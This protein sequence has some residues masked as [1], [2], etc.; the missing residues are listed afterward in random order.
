[1][2]VLVLGRTGMLGSMVYEV[3]SRA[4]GFE[5]FG[6]ARGAGNDHR[7]LALD[8]EQ[9]LQPQFHRL[10]QNGPWD[11]WINCIGVIKPHCKDADP[12]GVRRAI[13][14]NAIFPHELA[15]ASGSANVRLIQIATDCVYSGTKGGYIESDGHDALDVYGKTKSLGEVFNGDALNIRVSIIGPEAGTRWSLLEWFLAQA[16]GAEL[17]GFTHHKWNGIT[18][19]RFAKICENI[20]RQGAYDELL[21]TS[22]VHHYVPQDE[23]TKYEL[24]ELFQRAFGTQFKIQP[25]DAIGPRVDRTL[26]T[27]FNVLHRI[28]PPVSIEE[29]VYALRGLMSGAASA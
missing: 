21:E 9:P 20:I 16:P 11:Y 10:I 15:A 19:F 1:M 6:A 8:A 27:K 17:K 12:E 23:V 22:H 28:L 4:A 5:V 3:L 13:R 7:I 26:A 14:V 2:R 25:V 29:D 18:T 24:L